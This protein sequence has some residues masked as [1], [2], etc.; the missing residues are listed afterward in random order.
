MYK[1]LK[2]NQQL[3]MTK[4]QINLNELKLNMKQIVMKEAKSN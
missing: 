3:R 1:N 2:I 4:K